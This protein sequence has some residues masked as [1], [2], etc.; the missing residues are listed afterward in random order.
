LLSVPLVSSLSLELNP[1]VFLSPRNAG[2][3]LSSSYFVVVSD[4]AAVLVVTSTSDQ[5]LTSASVAS[6]RVAQVLCTPPQLPRVVPTVS[7]P[8][9][10]EPPSL[11]DLAPYQETRQRRPVLVVAG[12]SV[13]GR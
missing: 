4:H 11:L 7:Q 3:F 2:N 5:E 1:P 8:S 6:R 12:G 9:H 10:G 13:D